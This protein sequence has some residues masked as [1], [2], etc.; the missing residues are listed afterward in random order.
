MKEDIDQLTEKINQTDSTEEKIDALN[1]LSWLKRRNDIPNSLEM[2][3]EAYDLALAKEY[4]K[5]IAYG[6]V[7]LAFH[8]YTT[9]GNIHQSIQSFLEAI[10]IFKE[11]GDDMGS[12]VTHSLLSY[13]YW[14]SADYE[15]GFRHLLEGEEYQER[16]GNTEGMAWDK[17]NFGTFYSELNYYDQALPYFKDALSLFKKIDEYFG[18]A[19]AILGMAVIYKSHDD[20]KEAKECCQTA[21]GIA[22]QY[23]YADSK[24]WASIILGEIYQCLQESDQAIEWTKRSLE[25]YS[26]TGDR[27][28]QVNARFNLGTIYQAAGDNK[29]ALEYFKLVEEYALEANAL[30]N[31]IEAHNYMAELYNAEGE[32]AEALKHYKAYVKLKEQIMG[33]SSANQMQKMQAIFNVKQARQETEIQRLR[34]VELKSAYEEIELQ[35]EKVLSSIRYAKRI[36]EAIL[37]NPS[38]L[39]T[40]IEDSFIFFKP[41]DIVSGDFYWFNKVGDQFVLAA[42]DCTGH[43][44]PGAFMVLM[45]NA[46]LNDIILKDK[47][48]QPDEILYELDRRLLNSLS[49]DGDGQTNDGMDMAIVTFS[50]DR[51]SLEFAGA[52]N[53]LVYVRDG[54]MVQIKGS[55]FPIGSQQFKKPKV[56]PLNHIDLRKGDVFYTY[57]DGFQDQFGG[58]DNSKYLSKRFREFLFEISSLPIATQ[59]D[60]LEKELSDWIGGGKQT[61]DII[62]IG[63]KIN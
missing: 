26:K 49:S 63:F 7:N 27:Q 44:V 32:L 14:T 1:Q 60:K 23:G 61:D 11:I 16:S 41:K 54:E 22:E 46:L 50:A 47:I 9:Q 19:S 40:E 51:K 52:K 45:G 57:S 6:K 17:F 24:A 38:V 53:P 48:T 25:I 10:E 37:S 55:K 18:Q 2:A 59:K 42:I 21:I 62:I 8:D 43:G 33:D 35:K 30:L 15:N 4:K 5:G 36:Q 31:L 58:K 28:G 34:N 29:N 20:Y 13:I 56:F 3:K 39:N 12:G